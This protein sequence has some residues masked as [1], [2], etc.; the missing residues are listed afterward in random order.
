MSSSKRFKILNYIDT[1]G[2]IPQ[3]NI[4][5]LLFPSKQKC[6]FLIVDSKNLSDY[7]LKGVA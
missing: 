4:N 2:I 5:Q 1:V 7:H 3:A 6:K